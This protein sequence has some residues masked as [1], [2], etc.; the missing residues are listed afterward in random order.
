MSILIKWLLNA[1]F[2][3]IVPLIFR[4]IV[5]E[6]FVAALFAA[7]IIGLLN[8]LLKPIL[9]LLT[10]PI[11]ILTLG[12]FTLVIN[13]LIILLATKIVPGFDVSNIWYAILFA[14]SLSI[15]NWFIK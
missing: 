1:L 7:L 15:F 2:I 4:G 3:I 14:I 12:L 5:V 10:L 13:G 6:N 8:A 9:I 11:N